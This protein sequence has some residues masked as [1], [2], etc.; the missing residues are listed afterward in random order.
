MGSQIRVTSPGKWCARVCKK[1]AQGCAK[2]ALEVHKGVQRCMKRCAI[3]CKRCARCMQVCERCRRV[4][5]C[6]QIVAPGD[7]IVGRWSGRYECRPSAQGSENSGIFECVPVL[8]G[9]AAKNRRR[10][11]WGRCGGG[12]RPGGG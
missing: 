7:G 8:T 12:T 2:G 4:R 10:V 6:A 11:N 1:G 9:L 5:K 3:V